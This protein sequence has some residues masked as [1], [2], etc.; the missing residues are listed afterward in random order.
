M[1][2]PAKTHI[3]YAETNRLEEQELDWTG[4]F[5]HPITGEVETV[6]I[7]VS[8]FKDPNVVPAAVIRFTTGLMEIMAAGGPQ[9]AAKKLAQ[10]NSL[11][12]ELAQLLNMGD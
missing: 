4:K 11:D 3:E 1:L 2:D 9:E 5:S 7:R 6:N 12:D 8:G 10:G